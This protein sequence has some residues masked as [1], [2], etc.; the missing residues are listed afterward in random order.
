MNAA[1][2]GAEHRLRLPPVRRLAQGAAV[3]EDLR[4][5]PDHRVAGTRGG[6]GA[7]RPR[8]PPSPA[9]SRRGRR[10][11]RRRTPPPELHPQRA[12]QR[13]AAGRARREEDH[14][15]SS[16]KCSFSS[17]TPDSGL[18]DPWIT[19]CPTSSAKSPRIVSGRGVHRVRRAHHRPQGGDRPVG[20]LH[21]HHHDRTR[22][23]EVHQLAEEGP[24]DGARRSAPRRPP[25]HHRL[26]EREDRQ[27]AALDAEDDLPVRPAA[28][29]SGFTITN[30][31][32]AHT[33]PVS[34]SGH[35]RASGPC[36]RVPVGRP[37]PCLT[38]GRARACRR[39]VVHVARRG[40]TVGGHPQPE[41]ELREPLIEVAHVVVGR[42]AL[43]AQRPRE[44][45]GVGRDALAA[46]IR[47]TICCPSASPSSPSRCSSASSSSSRRAPRRGTRAA[48]DQVDDRPEERD[49]DRRAAHAAMGR[50]LDAASR[51]LVGPVDDA[52]H[53]STTER[54]AGC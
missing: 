30:D 43:L 17:R 48:D 13:P 14:P 9:R 26:L 45:L 21:R 40:R 20:T 19:F 41:L 38:R 39:Q 52:S 35:G 28:T 24:L 25:F 8:P 53:S 6:R 36:G 50:R 12:E 51:V 15:P 49:Q 33:S 37:A 47:P 27:A 22:G 18:S 2:Q 1:G 10:P 46:S 29:P 7:G 23:D 11:P 3:Q 16:G 42:D 31:A 54:A 4:V 32:L 34:G 5:G 44:V